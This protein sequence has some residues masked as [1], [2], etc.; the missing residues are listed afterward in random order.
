M[1]DPKNW[2]ALVAGLRQ[3]LLEHATVKPGDEKRDNPTAVQ[4]RRQRLEGELHKR[5]SLRLNLKMDD[6]EMWRQI[7]PKPFYTFR[8]SS[9]ING[10]IDYM[11]EHY[12]GEWE[13]L[14]DPEWDWEQGKVYKDG[15][16]VF[17]SS[18]KDSS[19]GK[20]YDEFISE[21]KCYGDHD[22]LQR[23]LT[24]ARNIKARAADYPHR[25]ILDNITELK[26]SF[27]SL[28]ELKVAFENASKY[29]R[30][31]PITT[32][33]L[34]TDLGFKVVKPDRVLSRIAINMGLIPEYQKKTKRKPVEP[35]T[36][37]KE[38]TKYTNDLDFCWALQKRFQEISE[39][40]NVPM[41]TLDYI[42]V[43]LGQEPDD[44]DGIATTICNEKGPL[45]DLCG[46]KQFCAEAKRLKR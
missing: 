45:C 5:D 4:E 40:T 38:V 44:G 30:L 26:K 31:G 13:P 14:C 33:H 9:T 46:A 34:L 43:K 15:K 27:N 21:P 18:L 41:R 37:N 19:N 24:A 36:T 42:F 17:K 16:Y 2:P 20:M 25:T 35:P 11:M 6:D 32:F 7:A 23:S 8:P 29:L 39:A 10:F 1:I 12:L 3:T 28:D 22:R